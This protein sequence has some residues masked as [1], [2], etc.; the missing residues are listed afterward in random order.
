M[1]QLQVKVNGL[2]E[3]LLRKIVFIPSFVKI[4]AIIDDFKFYQMIFFAFI[5]QS[6]GVYLLASSCGDLPKNTSL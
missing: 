1:S 2:V 5:R 6:Y 4:L 3:R